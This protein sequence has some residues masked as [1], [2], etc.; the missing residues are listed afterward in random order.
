[1]KNEE[2]QK[3][4]TEV[5]K[6]GLE[7]ID[8]LVIVSWTSTHLTGSEGEGVLHFCPSISPTTELFLFLTSHFLALSIIDILSCTFKSQKCCRKSH[9]FSYPFK[10][11][12]QLFCCHD[13]DSFISILSRVTE[14]YVTFK[15]TLF[16][17]SSDDSVPSFVWVIHFSVKGGQEHEFSN[18][19]TRVLLVFHSK[20][21]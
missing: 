9:R 8:S 14:K 13:N 12:H 11:E 17:H 7:Y 19:V 2:S 18:R 16:T 5:E 4:D 6:E 21:P 15:W 10:S 3:W 20:Y 1:M